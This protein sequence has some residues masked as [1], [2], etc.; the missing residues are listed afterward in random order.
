MV[1]GC[2]GFFI[3]IGFS[4]FCVMFLLSFCLIFW[5][6]CLIFLFIIGIKCSNWVSLGVFLIVWF[7]IRLIFWV[8]KYWCCFSLVVR[9]FCKILV[10][11]CVNKV[12]WW[13]MRLWI[14]FL[15]VELVFNLC[16]ILF[17]IVIIIWLDSFFIIMW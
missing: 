5:I 4:K 11:V 12:W 14:I 6:C 1:L 15:W 9:D 10:N 8:M 13:L 16:F 7:I 3:I 2:V 17:N